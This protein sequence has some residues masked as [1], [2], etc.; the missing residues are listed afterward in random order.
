MAN[1]N[2]AFGFRWVGSLADGAISGKI[3]KFYTNSSTAFYVG[4][5][6]KTEGTYG[7]VNPGGRAPTAGLR[8]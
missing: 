4:D 6:V 8:I 5:P 2:K 1:T 7:H 3:Q